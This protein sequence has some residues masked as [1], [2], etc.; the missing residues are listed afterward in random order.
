MR[1]Q[2]AAI[3]V[4]DKPY[5]CGGNLKKL[6]YSSSAHAVVQL[7][8]KKVGRKQRATEYRAKRV[9]EQNIAEHSRAVQPRSL[10]R[11][12]TAFL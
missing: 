4:Y 10:R 7:K 11:T 6:F 8:Y 1:H 2:F 9:R 3:F 12:V 5:I